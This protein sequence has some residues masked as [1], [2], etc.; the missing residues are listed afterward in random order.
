MVAIKVLSPT[1]LTRPGAIDTFLAEARNRLVRLTHPGI[2]KVYD[3]DIE[4]GLPFI[5]SRFVAGPTLSELLRAESWSSS[6]VA[7]VVG[8]VADALAHAHANGVFHRDVKPS[9]IIIPHEANPVLVDFGAALSLGEAARVERITIQGTPPYLS[10]EQA[11]GEGHRVDGRTDIFSLG[12]VFYQMLVGKTPYDDTPAM[13]AWRKGERDPKVLWPLFSRMHDLDAQPP[14]QVR[15]DVPQELQRICLRCL[16]K[17]PDA[18]YETAN[19]LAQ[20]LIAWMDSAPSETTKLLTQPVPSPG[21]GGR[22]DDWTNAFDAL[23]DHITRHFVGRDFVFDAIADF[24]NDE[25]V[26]SGYFIIEGDPGVGKST[27]LAQFAKQ[28]DKCISHFN[29]RSLGV[30]R[31]AQFVRNVYSAL[32][33]R[34]SMPFSAPSPDVAEDATLLIRILNAGSTKLRGDERI[35]IAIDALDEVDLTSQSPDANVLYLPE[36]LPPGVFIVMTSRTNQPFQL[37]LQPP[38]R[39][40]NLNDHPNRNRRDVS[41]Y[42]REYFHRSKL[43]AWVERQKLTTDDLVT[44]LAEKSENN[45]MYLT[46]VLPEL[47]DGQYQTA[48]ISELPVGLQNYYQDHWRRMGMTEPPL[49]KE[50]IKV[51]YVLAEA[52]QPVSR[53]MLSELANED[54]LLVQ[55]ILD[56]WAQFLHA[57]T[58]DRQQRYS[59]Y[60]NSFREFL[61]RKEVIEAAGVSIGD[62]N[63]RIADDLWKGLFRGD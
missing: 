8:D 11:R 55:Q 19:D 21:L 45:F 23:I 4:E 20:E 17:N 43:A 33:S 58:I 35:V 46:H 39:R 57:V 60:H 41:E 6:Q 3:A 2:A 1:R 50:R 29:R 14:R 42:I 37:V 47:K 40:L 34:L 25:A 7:K 49:P 53:R 10:P 16:Q 30:T 27:V 48:H 62:V 61:H 9:N 15:S 59:I 31:T 56:E 36:C 32:A 5:V 13:D 26:P 44:E 38:V 22:S 24:T 52:G 12:V 63:A 51:V 54:E 28:H 18:R